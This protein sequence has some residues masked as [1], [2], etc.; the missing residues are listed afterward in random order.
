MILLRIFR[1][2]DKDNDGQVTKKEF[3]EVSNELGRHM[4]ADQVEEII[5][6]AD[7]DDSQT[8]NYMEFAKEVHG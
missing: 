4:T 1:K 3:L 6:V 8:L 5:E 2:F 7:M